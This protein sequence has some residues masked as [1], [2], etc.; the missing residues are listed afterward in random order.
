[1]VHKLCKLDSVTACPASD[2]TSYVRKRGIK[3][4]KFSGTD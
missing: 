4:E 1:M 3:D 2:R